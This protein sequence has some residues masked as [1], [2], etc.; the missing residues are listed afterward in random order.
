MKFPFSGPWKIVV[1]LLC[2]GKAMADSPPGVFSWES[3]ERQLQWG[4]YDS[5]RIATEAHL[6]RPMDS[7][8]SARL[9]R[10]WLYRGAALFGL[11]Y[12]DAARESFQTAA[13]M[14]SALALD[15]FY[16]HTDI[17]A[18]YGEI[19]RDRRSGKIICPENK[20]TLQAV[21][22]D[23]IPVAITREDPKPALTEPA[24]TWPE[25]RDTKNVAIG[26]W[27]AAAVLGG[28]M[29]WEID[30]RQKSWKLYSEAGARGDSREYERQAKIFNGYNARTWIA[31]FTTSLTL[32]GGT[33]FT[34]KALRMKKKLQ[35]AWSG[36]SAQLAYRF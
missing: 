25:F 1:L 20:G 12:S 7:R 28:W 17:T 15:S 32:A 18:F 22:P 4:L 5:L 30:G 33:F 16:V 14:D 21:M 36:N 34:L 31:V 2:M 6:S 3:L 13:C 29:A 27:A 26:F 8:D 19:R 35:L 23:T 11:G 10:I 9:P 24:P